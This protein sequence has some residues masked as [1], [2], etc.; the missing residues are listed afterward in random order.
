MKFVEGYMPLNNLKNRNVIL[1]LN[2]ER[3]GIS[4]TSH[5]RCHRAYSCTRIKTH[6]STAISQ[7]NT[8]SLVMMSVLSKLD[9]LTDNAL[10]LY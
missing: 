10:L 2:V 5:V 9:K 1:R 4:F 6:A 7:S 3:N 8:N